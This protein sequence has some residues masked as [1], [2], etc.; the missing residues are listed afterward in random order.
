[1]KVRNETDQAIAFLKSFIQKVF[2]LKYVYIAAIVLFVGVA[3]IYNKYSPKVYELNST[4]GPL[5]DTRSSA[6]ASNDMF[7]GGGYSSSSAGRE[8]EAA[9]NSL[10]SF[11]L[12][13]K[14]VNDLNL[15][16]GYF[17]ASKSFFRQ[18]TEIY[19]QSPFIVNL[20]KSHIQAIGT[21]FNVS[22]LSNTAF[23]ITASTKEALL[24]NYIDNE[25]IADEVAI[26]FDTICKF[27]ETI[28][29][30]YFKFTIVPHQSFF[31]SSLAEN[32]FLFELYHPE[33]LAKAYMK[34][35]S[36]EPVSWLASI[37]EVKFSSTNLQKSLNFLN[38]YI[39]SFLEDNLEKKNK[40]AR[41]TI[42]FI[43]SQIS[44]M[45]DS[46]V[47]SESNLRN[48][49]SDNQVMDLSY[50][51]QQ[52]YSQMAQ[53]EIERT[54]LELQRRYYNYVLN[55]FKTNQDVSGVTPPTSANITDPLLNKLITD[56]F[57]L[58]SE[59]SAIANDGEK[60]LFSAQLDT[61]IKAQVQSIIDNVSN[62]LN[63]LNLTIN[64]L[65]YKSE[66]LTRDMSN[67]PRKEMNMVNIQRDF[68]RNN[69]IYTYLLQKKAESAISLSS[70]YP[71]FEVIEPAREVTS[72]VI[73]PKK[74]FN[75]VIALF[76]ALLFPTMFI[77]VTD[78]MSDKIGSIYDIETIIDKS[79]FGTIYSST[80]KSEAV[81]AESPGS[82]IA[83]SFRN[84]R[85]SLFLKMKAAGPKVILITSSQPQDGKSFISFNLSAS[86][87]SVGFNTVVLDCDLRRPVLHD[88]FKIENNKGISNYMIKKAT[89]GEITHAT[90]VENLSFIPAGPILTNPSELIE[91]GALEEL[92]ADLKTKFD[93]IIMDTPPLGLVS[94]SIQLMKYASQILIVSR[95]NATRKEIL[96]NAIASLET[97]NIENYEIVVNGQNL[98]KGPYSGYKGYYHKD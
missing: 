14:T 1:M 94:D 47:K 96:T 74:M 77:F 73:R 40:I 37:I 67:L 10:S 22:I 81:V 84:L 48:F 29:N 70:N 27:N 93:Y 58:N 71:D 18:Y 62:N 49:R 39:S 65:N 32:N 53:V 30:K 46:L 12:V 80:K 17:S 52:I 82:A 78:F 3:Y 68:D 75:Y 11:A 35:L 85:S 33:S 21:K 13:S 42:N 91:A 57:T 51:G 60:N 6:L 44:G 23:R 64:E 19:L 86:I 24:Y 79:V 4:I 8:L 50:Q 43:D 45:S 90:F 69:S 55:Y 38:S 87:A 95:L 76:L 9:V 7:R 36:V 59:K 83:E 72:E 92:I 88:K 2:G 20:D 26:N 63:T 89:A 54:N 41:N 98:D 34:S 15:E 28:T 16:I 25:I 66:K 56:L 61:K 5:K 31:P 97:N